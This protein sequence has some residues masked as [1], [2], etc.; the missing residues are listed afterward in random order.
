M[1]FLVQDFIAVSFFFFNNWVI[2][3]PNSINWYH[4][5]FDY[6]G[7]MMNGTGSQQLQVHVGNYDFWCVKMKTILLSYDLWD[8]VEDGFDE[9]KDPTSLS[10]AKKQQI[11]DHRK[12]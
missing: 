6:V 2:F 3:Q 12:K 5:L 4:S 1:S 10:I 8:Y 9:V 7:I 11:K